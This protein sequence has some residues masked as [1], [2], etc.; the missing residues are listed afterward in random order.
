MASVVLVTGGGA[1][2]G[3]ALAGAFH[4]RGDVVIIAGRTLAKLEAVA[5]R[6]PGMVTQHLDV[7][8]RA[9]VYAVADRMAEQHPTVDVL[10]N[11]AGVQQ[12]L[13][14]SGAGPSAEEIDREIDTNLRGVI[15]VSN[16]FLP[17]LKRQSRSRL[18]HVGS[19]LGFV[20]LARAPVYSATKAAV[21]SFTVSLRAQLAGT[22]VRVIELI[23]PVVATELHR[24]QGQRPPRAMP[25]ATFT[26]AAMRGLDGGQDEIAVGVAKLL[27]IGAR[28]AP[29]RL[30]QIVNTPRSDA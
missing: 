10:I 11:N 5:R 8:D 15:H 24:G 20:P 14:F 4:A 29:G 1:G 30:F 23:P 18:V 7:C 21:H 27:R 26:R 28:I 2:I 13:D 17:L 3:A 12:E 22:S 6:H 25:L 16:A 19:G 9:S